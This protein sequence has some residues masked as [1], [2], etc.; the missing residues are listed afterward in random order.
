LQLVVT[1]AKILA[2]PMSQ[3][4]FVSAVVLLASYIKFFG[5]LAVQMYQMFRAFVFHL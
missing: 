3:S 4:I 1:M 2:V 5:S